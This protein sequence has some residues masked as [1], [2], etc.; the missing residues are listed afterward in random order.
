MNENEIIKIFKKNKDAL[1]NG[2]PCKP[3][4]EKEDAL[5]LSWFFAGCYAGRYSLRK[6]INEAISW[7]Y[8]EG[9]DYGKSQT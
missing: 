2:N 1:T 6:N 3:I 8:A 5:A 7:R 4:N 9:A